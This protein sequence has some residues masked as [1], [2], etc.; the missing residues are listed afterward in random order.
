[1]Q[2]LQIVKY[3][4]IKDSLCINEIEKPYLKPMIF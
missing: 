1:M 2:A 4:E 3:V